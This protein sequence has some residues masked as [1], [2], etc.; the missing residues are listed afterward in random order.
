MWRPPGPWVEHDLQQ[1][2]VRL[3]AEM[4]WG[5]Q[6]QSACILQPSEAYFPGFATFIFNIRWGYPTRRPGLSRKCDNSTMRRRGSTTTRPFSTST[7]R[8]SGLPSCHLDFQ[9]SAHPVKV[10][11]SVTEMVASTTQLHANWPQDQSKGCLNDVLE[12]A[13][14]D[15]LLPRS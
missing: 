3:V 6:C 15:L 9:T 14:V 13:S 12:R 10:D 4:Q 11:G 7:C 5:N 8:V 1:F 2:T